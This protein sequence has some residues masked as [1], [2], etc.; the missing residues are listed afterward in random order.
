MLEELKKYFKTTPREK[1][2]ED[3]AKT[4]AFD[5][6][7]PTMDEFLKT[8]KY[9]ET[10]KLN[11]NKMSLTVKQLKEYL[12]SAPDD[13]IV[14]NE[15]NQDFIHIISNGNLVLSTQKPIAICNRSGGYIY[16]S[17]VT[18][19]F[20]YSIDLDENVYLHETTPLNKIQNEE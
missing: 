13:G 20:G 18:E 12:K 5:Q 2:L 1:V 8:Q 16:P 11:K 4:E 6:V 19:Y 17:D 15:Y 7:G 9:F 3:W 10:N 14:T